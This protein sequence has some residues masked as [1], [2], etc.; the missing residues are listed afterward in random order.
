MRKFKPCV[1]LR[2]VSESLSEALISHWTALFSHA[3]MQTFASSLLAQDYHSHSNVDGNEPPLSQVLTEAPL[4]APSASRLPAPSYGILAWAW[5]SPHS[6]PSMRLITDISR[7]RSENLQVEKHEI[8][9]LWIKCSQEN[10][11]WFRKIIPQNIHILFK[12]YIV[13][14]MFF[15]TICFPYTTICFPYTTIW[16]MFE[17]PYTTIWFPYT[18][19]SDIVSVRNYM[20]ETMFETMFV[21]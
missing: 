13:W 20:F 5:P 15:S 3:A 2:W 9:N 18:T 12:I 19:Y 10:L 17:N 11:W 1:A 16:Y 21:S 8:V 14:H 6:L 7:F 4:H